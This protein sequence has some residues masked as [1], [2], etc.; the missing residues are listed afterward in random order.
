MLRMET[1][2]DGVMSMERVDRGLLE[3]GT[4]RLVLWQNTNDPQ[5]V[6]CA[7]YSPQNLIAKFLQL[8][9]MLKGRCTALKLFFNVSPGISGTLADFGFEKF[10]D[11]T[12]SYSHPEYL[13]RATVNPHFSDSALVMQIE[14]KM[15]GGIPMTALQMASLFENQLKLRGLGRAV[16]IG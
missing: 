3:K 7:M 6:Q 12:W 8:R 9:I 4:D 10:Q 13:I 5:V 14:S 2:W 15:R 1:V 11:Q 16:T